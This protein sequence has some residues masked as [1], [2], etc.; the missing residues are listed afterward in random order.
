M[1]DALRVGSSVLR[2]RGGEG[3]WA[4][5]IHRVAGLGVLAFLALH[6]ADIFVAAF[7]PGLFNDLLFIY[8]G[9]LARV[10]EILLA[11]GLLYHGL[12]GLR[13]IAADFVPR[14]ASLK[15]ARIL[16][17]VQTVLFLALFIPAGYFMMVTLPPETGLHNNTPVALAVTFG[18]LAV[19]AVVALAASFAPSAAATA[20]DSDESVGNYDDAFRRIL[21]GTQRRAMDRFELNV[22]LFMRIS[23]F[24]LIVLALLHMYILHFQISVEAITF[25]TLI[26]RWQDPQFGWFW[27]S[28][29]LALLAFAF[30]HGMLGLRYVIED[31]V[32][33]IGWRRLLL[34]GAG[35][36]W[37]VLIL[38]GAWIIFFFRGTLA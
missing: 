30:T 22:W 3:Q 21:I 1:I 28:Y 19:P 4:W 26:D 14:L 16:F 10:G 18:I 24:L 32:H 5:A 34:L 23:G 8:K 15:T 36:F 27:R 38:M 33:S 13:I 25:Q 11:F 7:G 31:Y 6:I 35:A 9:P 20:I 17:Y 12:N 37:V 29:D 2:Y